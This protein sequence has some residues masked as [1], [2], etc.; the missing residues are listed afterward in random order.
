MNVQSST[1]DGF[2]ICA[3]CGLDLTTTP[4]IRRRLGETSKG[5]SSDVRERVLGLWKELVCGIQ[6]NLV[7]LNDKLIM[8][9]GCFNDFDKCAMKQTELTNK[10]RVAFTKLNLSEQDEAEIAHTES[11]A[12]T[13]KRPSEDG[14][15]AAQKQVV[16]HPLVLPS[17]ESSSP[18]AT[19][20]V[21]YCCTSYIMM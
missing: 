19:V 3:G 18:F 8:C 9:R 14:H 7:I 12:P 6:Q 5:C 13:R 2:V 10:L 4:K 16:E 11:P 21:F 1:R 17:N 20:S 15:P